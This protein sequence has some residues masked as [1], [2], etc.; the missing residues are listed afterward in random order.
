MVLFLIGGGEHRGIGIV[1]VVCKAMAMITNSCF[2]ASTPYHKSFHGFW[3][4]RGTGAATLDINMLHQVE[5]MR[6]AVLHSIFL[7]LHKAYDD[8]ES[9][10]GI[11]ILEGYEVGPRT[12][13]HL[14]RY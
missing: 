13:H 5:A 11:K 7:Y 2:T 6:E 1:E 9:Y 12:L 4:G 10:R 14:H 3:A 8:L